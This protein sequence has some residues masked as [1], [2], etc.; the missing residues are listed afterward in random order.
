MTP[1]E[2]VFTPLRFGAVEVKNRI[3][4][5]PMLSC[6]ATP[7]GFVTREMIAFYQAFARGGAG[8]VN[9]GDSGVDGEFGIGHFMQLNL[10]SDAV[11]GGLSTL[12]EAI[13][14]YGAVASVEINHTGMLGVPSVLGGRNPI[15]PSS[16]VIRHENEEDRPPSDRVITVTE[17]DQGLIDQVIDN[18]AAACY[19]CL[20]AGFRTVM[21][22]GAHGNLLAQFASP[23][24]NKRTDRYGGS[25]ENRA[26][27]V[28]EVLDAVR[29]KV[30]DRLA[31]EYR[32]SADEIAAGGM[33]LEETIEFLRLIAHRIDLVNVSVGGIFDPAC[34]VFMAQPTYLPRAFNVHRAEAI[35]KALDLPV[36]AV[37]SIRD[38]ATAEEIIAGGRAD[39][40]AMGRAHLADPEIVNKTRR[41]ERDDV[42]PCIR[43]G[44][45]G[46]RPARFLPVR[47]AVNPVAGREV[48]HRCIPVA[49]KR[50]KVVIAGGGPAGMQ[51]ALT[52]SS[53]GHDVVLLERE[54]S[55]G[56][57]LRYAAAPGFKAD[58]REYLDW[59][60]GQT[61]RS[62]VE[63][64][65]ETEATPKAVHALEPD[66]LISAVGAKPLIPDIPG[67]EGANVVWAGH[68]ETG[69][70]KT[71][72]SIVV[73]GAGLTGCETA[74]QLA[75]E[76]KE[77]VLIDMLPEDQ[78]AR[79]T[80]DAGR[81]ALL[82][83]LKQHGVQLKTEVTLTEITPT[84]AVVVD[85]SG[86]RIELNA[87]S[88]VLA[89]GM[90]ALSAESRALQKSAPESY[91]VGDCSTPRD[92]MAAIHEGFNVAVEL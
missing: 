78:I 7:D 50:K 82:D 11:I 26:R 51:A 58:M 15:G 37:G 56:G 61:Q 4:T 29:E 87:D 23:R 83:L 68:V 80:S 77:V 63:I 84:A 20:R 33:H 44:L 71:G 16:A 2:H 88:V 70:V 3:A 53:R 32:V 59:L 12:V 10:G 74:L 38:L 76:G 64:K 55:L 73:A 62:G 30:G 8:L 22:H 31:L 21:L 69:A 24:T 52:A 46:E 79:D 17:M 92:L 41:G 6:M 57:S 48:E 89:L 75:Q 85:A 47:C 81:M 27:F 42:R 43:C 72:R 54:K 86:G 28:L 35:K 60:I 49:S 90:E 36:V 67:V 45:C 19:R 5:S 91:I 40:V 14:K 39:M 34:V 1:Y 13:Q 25:L 65:L 9:I 66:V 18:F